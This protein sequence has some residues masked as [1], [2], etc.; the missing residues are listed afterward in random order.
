MRTMQRKI[1]RA[2]TAAALLL[3]GFVSPAIAGTTVYKCVRDGQTTLQDKPCPSDARVGDQAASTAAVTTVPSSHDPSPVGQWSGQVQFQENQ[4]GQTI[5]AAHSVALMSAEFRAD[6]KITGTSP[7][8]GCKML[9]VWGSGIG[10]LAWLVDVTFS[11]CSYGDL[12]RRF[13]GSFILAR[14]DSSA[15]MQLNSIGAP[16]SKDTAKTF[17]IT[18]TLH[19]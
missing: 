10:P 12:N 17:D 18:G 1:H 7:E 19:R 15:A 8:N 16:F 9:G 3:V 14:P 13:H 11:G 4:N 5:Q 2:A 6:G